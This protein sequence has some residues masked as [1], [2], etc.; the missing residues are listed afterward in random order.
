[1]ALTGKDKKTATLLGGSAADKESV[2][3]IIE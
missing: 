3:F 2:W 1:M